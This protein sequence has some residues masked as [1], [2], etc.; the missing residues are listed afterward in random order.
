MNVFPRKMKRLPCL[1]SASTTLNSRYAMG[2]N[3]TTKIFP[4]NSHSKKIFL[5]STL[6]QLTEYL[7][8]LQVSQL[9]LLLFLHRSKFI[10]LRRLSFVT[11]TLYL[12]RSATTLVTS[13]PIPGHYITCKHK[14]D[15]SISITTFIYNIFKVL[16]GGG[17]HISGSGTA[18]GD[19]LFSGHTVILLVC[20]IFTVHY[21]KSLWNY[22]FYKTWKYLNITVTVVGVFGVILSHEHYTIDVVCAYY[23]FKTKKLIKKY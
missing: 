19:Y 15:G 5:S 1:T 12:Y 6:F 10:I 16:L 11:G 4:P 8:L 21:T 13:L 3:Y 2:F 22:R 18:C 23:R 14:Y 17:T 9:V 7:G 20:T